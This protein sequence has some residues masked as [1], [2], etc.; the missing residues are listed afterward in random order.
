M[1][2]RRP[3]YGPAQLH[4]LPLQRRFR[5]R[6]HHVPPTLCDEVAPNF[7]GDGLIGKEQLERITVLEPDDTSIPRRVLQVVGT[8]EDMIRIG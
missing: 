7:R 5:H 3:R 6:H 1:P 8:G 4:P 2:F